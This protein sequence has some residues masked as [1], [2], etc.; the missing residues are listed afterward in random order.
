M[1]SI[2][3]LV[4]LAGLAGCTAAP[5]PP[6]PN[7]QGQQRL[8]QW[9]AGLVPGPP[10]S[11]LASYH[12]KEMTVADANTILFRET[13]GHVWVLK[14]QSPCSPLGNGGPYAL[15][16]RSTQSSLCKGD[17]ATVVDTTS[18]MTMGSCVI[19]EFIPYTRPR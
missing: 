4:L 1:R 17:I 14:T 8:A 16:T 13:R 9:T 3:P 10:Q 19:G 15:L 12:Q 5:P 18:G 7:Y 11:C 2:A 6:V